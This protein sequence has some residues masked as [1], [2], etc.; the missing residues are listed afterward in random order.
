MH[1]S[2]LNLNLQFPIIASNTHLSSTIPQP[3]REFIRPYRPYFADHNGCSR[4]DTGN[5]QRQ[6]RTGRS[7][8]SAANITIH[9]LEW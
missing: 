8:K 9:P 6:I 4:M 3:A 7:G 1:N 5:N 2:S